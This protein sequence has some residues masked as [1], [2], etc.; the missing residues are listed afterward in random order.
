MNIKRRNLAG[1]GVAVAIGAG[2]LGA[3]VAFG[4]ND[5]ERAVGPAADRAAGIALARFPG[6]RVLAVEHDADGGPPWEVE[7]RRPDGTAVDVELDA[8]YRI[9]DTDEDDGP[10]DADVD[11]S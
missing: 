7:L 11:D 10:D 8:G 6:A 1:A 2:A 3:T 5:D 4:G 9:V